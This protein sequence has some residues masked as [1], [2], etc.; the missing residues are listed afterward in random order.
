ML[1]ALMDRS[2]A[3]VSRF[4]SPVMSPARDPGG[5]VPAPLA[6]DG[7]ECSD[8]DDEALALGY[9]MVRL[10]K[11]HVRLESS[12]W[13][14]VCAGVRLSKHGECPRSG[15]PSTVSTLMLKLLL[16][17]RAGEGRLP[18]LDGSVRGV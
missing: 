13:D 4:I 6:L 15:L 1:S 2:R 16:R 17:H 12:L 3:L 10:E 11:D 8:S 5:P 7:D 18:V 9:E 14:N